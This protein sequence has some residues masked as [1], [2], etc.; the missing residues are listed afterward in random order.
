ML[1]FFM[2]KQLQ[3]KFKGKNQQ[4]LSDL[5]LSKRAGPKVIPNFFQNYWYS[6]K[7]NLLCKL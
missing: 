1:L 6:L 7:V 3:S 4:I 5:Q 2:S